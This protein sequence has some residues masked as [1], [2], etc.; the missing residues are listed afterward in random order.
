MK[1]LVKFFLMVVLCLVLCDTLPAQSIGSAFI[2]QGRLNDG[3]SPANG[4]YDLEFKLFDALIGGS[5]IGT[6]KLIEDVNVYDG[7][8]TVPLD[9]GSLAFNGNTRW[10]E[11]GVRPGT[12]TTRPKALAPRQKIT[13]NP[14]ALFSAGSDWR[15]LINIPGDLA[16]GDDNTTLT[17]AQVDV[18]VANNGF[19]DS[20]SMLNWINLYNVPAGFADGVDD[21]GTVDTDW[22]GAGT[23]KM[24]AASTTDKVGIGTTNPLY[25]LEVVRNATNNILPTAAFRTTGSNSA[26]SIRLENSNGNYF[27]LGSAQ[28]DDFALAYNSNI[29]QA[30]DL[31]RITPD[32][33]LGLNTNPLYPLHLVANTEYGGYFDNNV[34]SGEGYGLYS[35]A[36]GSGGSDHYGLYG[37]AEGAIHNFGVYGE[38][39]GGVTH[40]GGYFEGDL[41][42]S[43]DTGIGYPAKG[44]AKLHVLQ[45][46]T[47]DTVSFFDE[48]SDNSPFVIKADGRV[49]IG[50][51]NPDS[52]AK[53]HV[54]SNKE[55]TG[56]FIST[57]TSSD[58]HVIHAEV[59]G[60]TGYL[61]LYNGPKAVY[62]WAAPADHVG[63]GGYFDGGHTGVLG[64]VRPTGNETYYGVRASAEHLTGTGTGTNIG[65]ASWSMFA[66]TNYGV[67]GHAEGGDTNYGIIGFAGITGRSYAG[68]FL[69]KVALNKTSGNVEV[70]FQE[71]GEYRCAVGYSITDGHMYLYNGGNV[72]VK[73]GKLGVG[74]INP[75]Y[76]LDVEGDIECTTLHETSDVRLKQNIQPLT[77][78]LDK[79]GKL[80]GISFQWKEPDGSQDSN[81]SHRQ[82]G[83]IA[84][85]VE[86]VL[87]ELVAEN[88]EG[89][90]SVEYTKFTAVL[91]EAVK[92]LKAENEQLRV[93]NESFS[94]RLAALEQIS[95]R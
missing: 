34:T 21:V 44:F 27:T 14:Y 29:S 58:T 67:Y 52:D 63:I 41:F 91:I 62:G 94:K 15:N 50:T 61:D 32:G 37:Y 51:P 48:F 46:G 24:Y 4:T 72:A 38:A 73:S 53:M 66:N 6:T 7:Y 88:N 59:T 17:E 74:T 93:Q 22:S 85:E 69:G 84:Q 18:Y 82:I 76:K 5:Q 40:Y 56:Y 90:K 79:V 81:T 45:Q 92:E 35:V 43:G 23:G 75:S 28:N 3:G 87:P 20:A 70:Q 57:N 36:D 65:V 71:S 95:Q 86:V 30:G 2:Y 64:V 16:D 25:P 33:H 12:S 11:I 1:I 77:Q 83:V 39:V 10:L 68:Y 55:N 49:G 31:L 47:D 9:F 60:S 78:A 54:T 80:R 42:A 89:Y 19:L 8:F 26:G 13:P